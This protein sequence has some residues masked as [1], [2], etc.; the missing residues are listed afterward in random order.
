MR[1]VDYLMMYTDLGMQSEQD[2]IDDD[3]LGDQ[4]K[5]FDERKDSQPIWI[6]A[7]QN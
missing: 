7:E 1:A 5:E 6:N 3:V 2:Q 4:E